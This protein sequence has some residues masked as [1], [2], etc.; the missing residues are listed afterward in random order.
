MKK[1]LDLTQYF[2][3]GVR[4]IKLGKWRYASFPKLGP[5]MWTSIFV[6]A[7]GDIY[8]NPYVFFGGI[9][10]ILYFTYCFFFLRIHKNRQNNGLTQL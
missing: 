8:N 9:P 5:Y 6:T 2:F 10:F 1:F 7:L 4:T 3:T